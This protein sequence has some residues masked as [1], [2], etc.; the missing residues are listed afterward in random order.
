MGDDYLRN[1]DAERRNVTDRNC[2]HGW[3]QAAECPDCG[4]E[5]VAGY[6][7]EDKLSGKLVWQCEKCDGVID[8]ATVELE[9]DYGRE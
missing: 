2:E 8:A 5:H 1:F 7:T 3:A 6:V 9:E 4:A